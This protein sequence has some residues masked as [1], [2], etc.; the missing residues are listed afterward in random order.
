M[1]IISPKANGA[2]E[3]AD[4]MNPAD[5]DDFVCLGQAINGIIS[6]M[7]LWMQTGNNIN[8]QT[9]YANI[10]FNNR[11]VSGGLARRLRVRS[12]VEYNLGN[13]TIYVRASASRKFKLRENI[14]TDLSTR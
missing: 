4:L 5:T 14:S 6:S 11:P 13:S 3:A 7:P 1:G 10:T 12:N 8:T 2:K 9:T